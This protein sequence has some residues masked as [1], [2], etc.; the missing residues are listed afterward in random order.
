M[1]KMHVCYMRIRIFAAPRRVGEDFEKREEAE[2]WGR[3]KLSCRKRRKNREQGEWARENRAQERAE[4]RRRER[5][6]ERGRRGEDNP[7]FRA[8]AQLERPRYLDQSNHAASSAFYHYFTCFPF[9]SPSLDDISRGP[10]CDKKI[11]FGKT[12]REERDSMLS[13]LAL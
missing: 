11:L 8:T 2:V 7:L 1:W 3:G 12:T 6:S 10:R 5:E 9:T 4:R 13:R